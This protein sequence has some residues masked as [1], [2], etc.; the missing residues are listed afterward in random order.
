MFLVT[1]DVQARIT[2]K[3]EVLEIGCGWGSFALEVVRQIGCKYTGITLSEDQLKYAQEK[4]KEAGFEDQ[5]KLLMCDYRQLPKFQNEMLEAVGHEYMEEFFGCCESLLAEDGIF[6]LQS[7]GMVK[8]SIE[9]VEN[10]GI[11]FLQTLLSWRRNFM[12]NKSEILKLGFDEKFIRTWDYYFVYCAA[13]FKSRTLGDYQVKSL[14]LCTMHP[15]IRALC[16]KLA[17]G[18]FFFFCL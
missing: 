3:H 4:V 17:S 10:I 2:K 14:P 7:N 9:H 12:A 8:S 11:H 6:V 16:S 13:G 18:I 1:V 15:L 5:I